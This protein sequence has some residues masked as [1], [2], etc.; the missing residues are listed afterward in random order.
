MQNLG[1]L[2]ALAPWARW[3]GIEPDQRRRLARR[4]LGYF[5]TN[6]YLAPYIVGGL[7]RL[8]DDRA[9]GQEVSERLVTGFHGTLSRVCGAIGDKLFWLGLR[10]AFML[11][12]LLLGWLV[13]WPLALIVVAV[14]AAAQLVLR[15]QGLRSGFELGP[16]VVDVLDRPVWHRAASWARRVALALTGVL[17]GVFFAG[18]A[19]DVVTTHGPEMVGCVVLGFVLPLVIQQRRSGEV[20]LLLGLVGLAGLALIF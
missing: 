20:Q 7:L 17:L 5:N 9:G 13:A 1:L 12:A 19:G 15:C 8:E 2:A 11:L 3:R 14:F 10:P 6:P 4:Y 18:T 16:E